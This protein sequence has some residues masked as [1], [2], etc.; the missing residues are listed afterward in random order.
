MLAWTGFWFVLGVFWFMGIA[1]TRDSRASFLDS[2]FVSFFFIW[3]SVFLGS[4]WGALVCLR[5]VV[6]LSRATPHLQSAA[7]SVCRE[8]TDLATPDEK[9]AHL[10]KRKD[11]SGQPDTGGNR[12]ERV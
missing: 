6:R 1:A 10:L 5:R 12:R 8:Q 11:E 3:G 9:L 7:P 2:P 4:L